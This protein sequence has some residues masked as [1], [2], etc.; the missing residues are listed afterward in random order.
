MPFLNART[1]IVLDPQ[2]SDNTYG[3][4]QRML[5]EGWFALEAVTI[6]ESSRKTAALN[7][8]ACL[9]RAAEIGEEPVDYEADSPFI[10]PRSAIEALRVAL[11][12]LIAIAETMDR[13]V[14]AN[15]QREVRMAMHSAALAIGNALITTESPN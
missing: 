2:S 14:S 12:S 1:P 3:D 7:I 10:E 4:Y 11:R 15:K 9:D 8:S 13:P 5:A 6:D